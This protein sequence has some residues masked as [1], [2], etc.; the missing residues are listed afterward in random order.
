[1]DPKVIAEKTTELQERSK[2][3]SLLHELSGK[4]SVAKF[5]HYDGSLVFHLKGLDSNDAQMVRL[6]VS[7]CLSRMAHA[8][9][10]LIQRLASELASPTNEGGK[11]PNMGASSE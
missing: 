7:D 1:M 2:R 3:A 5:E 8:Q 6:A 9:I 10:E 11:Q 4:V